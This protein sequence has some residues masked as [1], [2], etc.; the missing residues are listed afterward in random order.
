MFKVIITDNFDRDGVPE[1]PFLENFD[2]GV[3]VKIAEQMNDKG[4]KYSEDY[5][6]VVPQGHVLNGYEE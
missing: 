5:Y 6:Q 2:R 4:S 1:R 3:C